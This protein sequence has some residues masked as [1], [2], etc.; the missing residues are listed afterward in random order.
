[1]REVS[2]WTGRDINSEQ[3]CRIVFLGVSLLELRE[4]EACERVI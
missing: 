1:M 4:H 3:L 2:T